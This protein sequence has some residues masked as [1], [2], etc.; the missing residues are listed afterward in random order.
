[1]TWEVGGC[2]LFLLLNEGPG[3]GHTSSE[4]ASNGAGVER[5]TWLEA[6]IAPTLEA[7]GFEVVR[8]AISGGPRRTLQVMADRRDGS[9]ISVHECAEIS[10]TLST[11]FDV[12]GPVQGVYDLE[13]SSAGIDRPLTRPK[14]FAA[15]AGFEAKVET[16]VPI[17]GRRRFKG[18]LKGLNT[19]GEV[20]ITVDGSDV[21]LPMDAIASAKLVLTD[22]LIA[23]SAAGKACNEN[24]AGG[25]RPSGDVH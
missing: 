6:R 10:R 20:A 2:P 18:L 9:L 14:D 15:Y 25:E 3:F 7:M 8:V 21:M 5:L 24:D 12:E 23:A 13:V 22:Q 11:I 19:A 17:A 1:M 4:L 16:R